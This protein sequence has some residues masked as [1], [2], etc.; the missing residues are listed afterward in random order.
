MPEPTQKQRIWGWYFFD[1]AS[2]PYNTLLITFI[3]GPYINEIIGDGSK[4][5]TIWAMGIAAAGLVI[6]L[7]SP[8]FGALADAGGGRLRW[9]WLFSA[10]YILGA[11]G[12]W[13]AKPDDPNLV[14]VLT[15]FALGMVGMEFA[16]SFTNALLPELGP[17]E[18]IGKISGTGWAFGYL[19]GLVSLLVMLALF[20]ET[21]ASGKTYLGIDPILGLDPSAREGT[22]F[23]GP[24]TAIWYI[25]FMIPFA[26]WVREAP[27][28]PMAKGAMGRALGDLGRTLKTLPK[29]KNLSNFLLGSMFYRDALNAVYA[30]GGLYAAGVLGW[31][32][33]DSGAFGVIAI[34]SGAIFTWLGGYAD[35]KFGPKRL[36]MA[37]G[38]LLS[39]MVL[40]IAAISRDN[41]A[42][43]PVPSGSRLPDNLFLLVGVLVG[44]AGGAIQSASRTMMVRL[45]DPNRMTEAFG[46]YALT[47]KATSFLA[48]ALIGLTTWISGSQQIGMLPLL[49]LFLLGLL[50]LSLVKADGPDLG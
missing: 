15:L 19:G 1:W 25:L 23:V 42:G 45:A 49:A 11:A 3:F 29:R 31:S 16:T 28:A 12:L 44:A 41:L 9:V 10:F 36:I 8:V 27:S 5:Q 50:L 13:W 22:R 4:A 18:E 43:F 32:A 24:F 33:V 14:L 26:L 34:L 40:M 2:Q 6:A 17:A 46:L 48:P 7:L 38:I 47:G 37:S 39:L 20:A 30:I 21:A 35:A